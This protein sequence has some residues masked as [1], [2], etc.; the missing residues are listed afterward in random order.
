MIRVH[1][2]D[3]KGLRC[4]QKLHWE[5]GPEINILIGGNGVGKTSLL[6]A[7]HLT[8]GLRP[9]LGHKLEPLIPEGQDHGFLSAVVDSD[10]HRR[11]IDIGFNKTQRR[12][13]VDD[14]RLRQPDKLLQQ[15]AV[16]P[17]VPSDLYLVQGG[18]QARRKLLD[19]TAF[20][21]HRDHAENLRRYNQ[22]LAARNALLRGRQ[23]D[24]ALLGVWSREL[25]RYGAEI[26]R[27]RKQCSQAFRVH[28]IKA[29][30]ALSGAG[31]QLE[32]HLDSSLASE[33]PEAQLLSMLNQ[34]ER[35]DLKRGYTSLGPHHDDWTFT[36]SGR[37][38]RR[39]ASQGQQRSVV[40]AARLALVDWIVVHRGYR[41]VL[42][43]D[44]VAGDLDSARRQQLFNQLLQEGGQVFVTG[45]GEETVVPFTDQS[46]QI[47]SLPALAEL[48]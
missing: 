25:A 24:P 5:P 31:E 14:K 40:L 37:Q 22:S 38:V 30:E 7:V 42:L 3:L 43:L 9:L 17:F 26:Y 44:D 39:H 1:S 29:Y 15:Q 2:L 6:E 8:L 32:A 46:T 23:P 20:Y 19:Q 13:R 48:R 47:W 45:T 34:A 28:L 33:D 21:Q 41:P 11:Q 27:I 4:W 18:P 10:G 12:I 16:V 36:L 35:K